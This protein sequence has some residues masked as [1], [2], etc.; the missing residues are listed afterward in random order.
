[1]RLF[2][3]TLRGRAQLFN[4]K[5]NERVWKVLSLVPPETLPFD[6]AVTWEGRLLDLN[7]TL[8]S[9]GVREDD[10][11]QAVGAPRVRGTQQRHR[12]QRQMANAITQFQEQQEREALPNDDETEPTTFSTPPSYSATLLAAQAATD[13]AEMWSTTSAGGPNKKR[14]VRL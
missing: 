13:A 12:R 9:Y 3:R 8:S 1:M 14:K 5:E 7:R 4:V 10:I 6:Y 11:I 2:I